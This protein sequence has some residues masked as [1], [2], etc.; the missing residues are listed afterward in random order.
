MMLCCLGMG[1]GRSSNSPGGKNGNKWRIQ[2]FP[3]GATNPWVWGK[4]LLLGK[5]FAK[6]LHENQRNQGK[7][8]GEARP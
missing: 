5:M 4:N 7:D 6:K 3:D 8:Q 2:D 1:W